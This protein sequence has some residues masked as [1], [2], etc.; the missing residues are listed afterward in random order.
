MHYK[1]LQKFCYIAVNVDSKH[2]HVCGLD[3][4]YEQKPFG[5]LL[6]LIPIAENITRLHAFCKKCK[7]GT[8]ASFTKRLNDS[9]KTIVLW[10]TCIFYR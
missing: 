7:D 10:S 5:E 4:D 2:V 8:L 3:G 6:T 9:K 1:N